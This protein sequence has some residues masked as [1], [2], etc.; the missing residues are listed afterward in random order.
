MRW[1]P[2]E[3]DCGVVCDVSMRF[4]LVL[5]L[6]DTKMSDDVAMW[7]IHL[8]EVLEEVSHSPAEILI[9]RSEKPLDRATNS[10]ITDFRTMAESPT[11]I[12]ERQRFVSIL[13]HFPAFRLEDDEDD[14]A[15]IKEYRRRSNL[16]PFRF[17]FR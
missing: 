13:C 7:V 9:R 16:T 2:D 17:R 1:S 8:L 3:V 14:Q 11:E 12:A 4:G 10:S 5:S 15:V 6:S